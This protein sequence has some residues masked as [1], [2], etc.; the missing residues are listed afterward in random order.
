MHSTIVPAYIDILPMPKGRGLR[1][2][3]V[4]FPA[5]SATSFTCAVAATS[6]RSHLHRPQFPQALRYSLLLRFITNLVFVGGK[7]R[8][9]RTMVKH[10]SVFT[11][12][13]DL[14]RNPQA[15]FRCQCTIRSLSHKLEQISTKHEFLPIGSAPSIP[16]HECGGLTAR[17]DNRPAHLLLP[18][19]HFHP[20]LPAQCVPHQAEPSSYA[21]GRCAE[22]VP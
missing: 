11:R 13:T 8:E 14:P 2:S 15:L 7:E 1:P 6:Q 19:R 18:A 22:Q 10:G 4:G 17:F 16:M 12:G 5:S 20:V 9:K 3:R 21:P